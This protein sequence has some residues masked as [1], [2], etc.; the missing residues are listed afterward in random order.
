MIGIHGTTR[1][2]AARH[3][4]VT[5]RH[6]GKKTS[7]RP[8]GHASLEGNFGPYALD[9]A[10]DRRRLRRVADLIIQQLDDTAADAVTK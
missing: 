8:Q 4:T 5:L 1:L 9:F 2:L 7:A 6:Y 3:H 10:S